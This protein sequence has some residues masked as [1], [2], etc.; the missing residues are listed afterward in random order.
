MFR[1]ILL[2]FGGMLIVSFLGYIA[3][4]YWLSQRAP[5]REDFRRRLAD[6]QMS[7]AVHAYRTGGKPELAA[8]IKSLDEHF[9]PKHYLVDR[10]GRDLVTS[11]SSFK[12]V[13]SE[14]ELRPRRGP[15]PMLRLRRPG[16]LRHQTVPSGRTVRVLI[17]VEFHPDPFANLAV[18]AWIVVVIILM[19]YVLA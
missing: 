15:R 4:S 14:Q 17:E 8:F 11:G 1:R 7:Q 16:T 18:Y 9:P 13:P 12:V 2:W 6:F 10:Q 3:T 19:C 5:F